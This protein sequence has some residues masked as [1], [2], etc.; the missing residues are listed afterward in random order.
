MTQ[1]EV[2]DKVKSFQYLVGTTFNAEENIMF[3]PPNEILDISPVSIAIDDYDI[4]IKYYD[5]KAQT[6]YYESYEHFLKTHHL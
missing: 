6:I 1:Q 2:I 3:E 4:Q 5:S